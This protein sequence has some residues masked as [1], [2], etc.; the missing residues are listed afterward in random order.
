MHI[1]VVGTGY[2][3]L[4]SGAGM[5]DFGMNVICID[6]DEEKIKKLQA[7]EIP[8]YEPGLKELVDKNVQARRLSFGTELAEAVRRA[9][10][11]FICVGT[12]PAPDGSADLTYIREVALSLAAVIDDYKV[13]VTSRTVPPAPSSGRL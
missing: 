10:V 3:G 11:V 12:P 2:V 4:V 8:F 9:L 1:A 6:K 5:A 7:G 13:L